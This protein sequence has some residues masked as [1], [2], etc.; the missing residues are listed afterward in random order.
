MT[1]CQVTQ[2]VVADH[3][4]F[5]GIG[6][7]NIVYQLP[8]AELEDRK[9]LPILLDKVEQFWI[10]G[11]LKQS[12][13]REVI[14]QI[15]KEFRAEMEFRPWEGIIETPECSSRLTPN[16]KIKEIFNNNEVGRSL[17]ILGLSLAGG[18]GGAPDGPRRHRP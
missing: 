9:N 4:I 13:Y 8:P 1:N 16:Q 14:I 6:D 10:E 17:L 12:A 7:I 11:V 15:G 3:N 2:T 5:T 18:L